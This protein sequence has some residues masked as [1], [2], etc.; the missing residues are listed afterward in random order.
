MLQFIDQDFF[1]QIY[2][3][4]RRLGWGETTS[5]CAIA[6]RLGDVTLSRAV[7]KAL[8]E[9]PIPLIIP[10]HRVLASDNRI[11]GYSGGNGVPTKVWL[12]DHEGIAHR[13]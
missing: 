5:Y 8:G 2:A 13:E 12:L 11:T 3:A 4:T 6:R 1:K 9:N 10:C 7:G